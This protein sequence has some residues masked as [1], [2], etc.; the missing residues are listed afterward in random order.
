MIG[1]E[2][3][4]KSVQNE[5][6]ELTPKI[7]ENK[8]L[9]NERIK[10]IRES[11]VAFRVLSLEIEELQ[12]IEYPEEIEVSVMVSLLIMMMMM[13]PNFIYKKKIH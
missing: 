8:K 13:M 3:K 12:G 11:E 10:S 1:I 6:D 9:L 5:M 4:I 7:L 2:E